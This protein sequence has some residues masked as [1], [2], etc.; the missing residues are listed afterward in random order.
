MRDWVVIWVGAGGFGF[1]EGGRRDG[2][3]DWQHRRDAR[4]VLRCSGLACLWRYALGPIRCAAV[5]RRLSPSPRASSEQARCFIRHWHVLP[6]IDAAPP[7]VQ[8][9]AA[10]SIPWRTPKM[11]TSRWRRAPPPPPPSPP[12]PF[13]TCPSA[14]SDLVRAVRCTLCRCP[15]HQTADGWTPTC[16]IRFGSLLNRFKRSETRAWRGVR[17]ALFGP[18]SHCR[19]GKKTTVDGGAC[20]SRRPPSS[21]VM[22]CSSGP[23]VSLYVCARS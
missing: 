12:S 9:V 5:H 8:P 21:S 22:R 23:R 3:D 10:A 6:I 14:L 13:P 15:Q 7:P 19:S 11:S 16:P 4:A 17:T 2:R 20:G 18:I 1:Q